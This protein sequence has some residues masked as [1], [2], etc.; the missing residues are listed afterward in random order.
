MKK[1][2]L[3]K[4]LTV[5][6]SMIMI[7]GVMQMCASAIPADYTVVE[8][9][10]YVHTFA[11]GGT[12]GFSG[13]GGTGLALSSTMGHGDTKSLEVTANS[14]NYARFFI[15]WDVIA[16]FTIE[17][18]TNYYISFWYY[19][20]QNGWGGTI[21]NG[22]MEAPY[23][24]AMPQYSLSSTTKGQWNK[25][26]AV[27]T[28]GS[29]ANNKWMRFC[30]WSAP[31]GT[32]FYV[33]DIEIAKISSTTGLTNTVPEGA[34]AAKT[35]LLYGE[36]I[37]ITKH[38]LA[39][40]T[41]SGDTVSRTIEQAHWSDMSYKFVSAQSS[42]TTG[43]YVNVRESMF[44]GYSSNMK[45]K[46]GVPYYISYYVYCPTKSVKTYFGYINHSW[47]INEV[48]PQG[49]WTKVSALFTPTETQANLTNGHLL[50]LLFDDTALDGV[51]QPVYLDDFVFAELS[52]VTEMAFAVDSVDYDFDTK[53]AEVTLDSTL[54]ITSAIDTTS[55][56][57][58][59]GV[60]VTSATKSADGKNVTV[61]LSGVASNATVGL[62]FTGV[63]DAF[64]RS[65]DVTASFTTPSAYEI[66]NVT[67]TVNGENATY[68]RSIVK[69]SNGSINAGMIVAAYN[70]NGELIS[71]GMDLNTIA[72][73]GATTPFSVT[74]AK[75]VTY[76]VFLL[77]WADLASLE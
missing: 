5:I 43:T 70:A 31:A 77:D 35:S 24:G 66:G 58:P 28:S 42:S 49:E 47:V 34:T 50:K 17:P 16:P 56:T 1:K 32:K 41:N 60:T 23:G 63:V 4:M 76:K 75:G 18:N 8:N 53:T 61:G 48:I 6:M 2:V 13:D 11:Q 74:I 40:G 44:L 67:E 46:A 71:V 26:M 54:E 25:A 39:N 65:K 51:N 69:N 33:D 3:T 37:E 21:A 36:N 22:T 19:A 30:A 14:S 12:T 73:A 7:L 62:T 15:T 45:M 64:G 29:N 27:M 9:K 52:S 57:A 38:M 72:G 59:Q 10:H 20:E 68:T 55:I